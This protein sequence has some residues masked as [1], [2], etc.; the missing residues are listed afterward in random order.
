L[1]KKKHQGELCGA[2]E[3]I[4][5]ENRENRGEVPTFYSMILA[6]TLEMTSLPFLPSFSL[7]IVFKKG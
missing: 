5:V 2:S 3:M 1:I 7:T 6:T 4:L